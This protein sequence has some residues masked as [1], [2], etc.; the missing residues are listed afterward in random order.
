MNQYKEMDPQDLVAYI[1]QLETDLVKKDGIIAA[2]DRRI[3]A[4][5]GLN[6]STIN[7]PTATP[8]V[9]ATNCSCPHL[10]PK[11]ASTPNKSVHVSDDSCETDSDES[12]ASLGLGLLTRDSQD[13]DFLGAS[14]SDGRWNIP[15]DDSCDDDLIP[16]SS[17]GK[18]HPHATALNE[19]CFKPIKDGGVETGIPGVADRL[20]AISFT[21]IRPVA[22]PCSLPFRQR[23]ISPIPETVTRGLLR[24]DSDGSD[25]ENIDPSLACKSPTAETCNLSQRFNSPCR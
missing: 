7:K 8:D 24:V 15:F 21:P 1:R 17:T 13:D 22:I 5:E 9:R 14:Q 3:A 19:L 25:K 11:N 18:A 6:A 2:Q 20:A 12:F 16:K 4:L 23:E 10:H